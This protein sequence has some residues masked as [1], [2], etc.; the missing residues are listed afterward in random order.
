[1]VRQVRLKTMGARWAKVSC[2]G[3]SVKVDKENSL[4]T[5]CSNSQVLYTNTGWSVHCF[6]AGS[7]TCHQ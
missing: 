4:R 2:G 1:M 3:S 6:R 7:N 5:V